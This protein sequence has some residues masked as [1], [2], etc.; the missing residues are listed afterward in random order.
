M[1]DGTLQTFS[2]P[3]H[4]SKELMK[5]TEQSILSDAGLK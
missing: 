3:R 5:K 4:Y 2:V 1:K